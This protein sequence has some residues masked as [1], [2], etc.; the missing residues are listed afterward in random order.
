MNP[1]KIAVLPAS[2]IGDA[3]LMMIASHQLLLAGADVTTFHNALPE[4]S[5]WFPQH[6]LAPL[7]PRES[8]VETLSCFDKIIIENDNSPTIPLLRS[9]WDSLT[10]PKLAIFYPSYSPSKHAE[11]SAFDQV[12]LPHL[13][14][15]DNIERAIS[16]LASIPATKNNGIHPP[17]HLIHRRHPKRVVIHPTSSLKQ[18]NWLETRFVALAEKLQE[19]GFSPIFSVSPLERQEWLWVE[20]KGCTLANLSHLPDFAELVYESGYLIGNDSLSGHL[21]SNLH[22]PTLIIASDPKHM[23]LWQPGW[24]A[25]QCVFPPRWLPNIK[26]LRLREK[27]WQHFISVRAALKKFEIII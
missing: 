13:T 2:G 21:A 12:F 6:R 3:L 1:P 22:I 18:K 23:R 7:P 16:Q 4:L 11:L 8:L 19:R 24:L 10:G 15:A 14:M 26:G 17:S 5:G 9:A 25:P 27:K 20:K